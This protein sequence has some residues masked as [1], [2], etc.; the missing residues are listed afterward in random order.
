MIKS[1]PALVFNQQS[2]IVSRQIGEKLIVLSDFSTHTRAG[3]VRS[4]TVMSMI[5][6]LPPPGGSPDA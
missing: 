3:S 1:P 5:T 6:P 2:T 4:F